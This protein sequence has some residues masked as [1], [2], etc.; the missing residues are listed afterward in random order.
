MI[1]AYTA[2]LVKIQ[3]KRTAA[4]EAHREMSD[5]HLYLMRGGRGNC[6]SGEDEYEI[7]MRDAEVAAVIR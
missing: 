3:K 6:Y 2:C 4:Y 5:E 7:I 1:I